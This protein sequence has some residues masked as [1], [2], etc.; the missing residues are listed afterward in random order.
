[1]KCSLFSSDILQHSLIKYFLA[2]PTVQSSML[3]ILVNIVVSAAGPKDEVSSQKM[4]FFF[5]IL[6]FSYKLLS[7]AYAMAEKDQVQHE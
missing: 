2:V 6:I 4:L 5:W 7:C 3:D 1:M